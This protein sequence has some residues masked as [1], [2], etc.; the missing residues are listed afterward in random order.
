MTDAWYLDQY[1]S[2]IR[3]VFGAGEHDICLGE[4]RRIAEIFES[5][6][7]PHWFDV[8]GLGAS[9]DWPLWPL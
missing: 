8:W 5:K 1:R 4:N 3:W 2:D 9:H 6:G 7:L